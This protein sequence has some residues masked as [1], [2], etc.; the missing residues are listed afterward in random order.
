MPEEMDEYNVV[1][2][3]EAIYDVTDITD[4]IEAEFGQIRADRFQD[5]INRQMTKL[6]YMGGVFPKTQIL[7]R[8]YPIH[9]KP[10]PPAIILYVL[11]EEK[12]EVHI[13]RVLREERDWQHILDDTQNYTYPN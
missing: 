3:W 13:L 10:F 8:N 4:Y 12:R 1:L 11:M 5:D 9:K 6:G 2:T 7:Y